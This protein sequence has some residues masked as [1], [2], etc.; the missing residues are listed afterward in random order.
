MPRFPAIARPASAAAVLAAWCA[1]LFCFAAA[2]E[3]HV[4]VNSPAAVQGGYAV[5]TFN[6]PTESDTASTLG[7]RLQLPASTPLAEVSVE[8][9]TGWKF[10]VITGK[11]ATPIET[12]DGPVSEA[13]SEIDWTATGAG[14]APGEF[15]QF[16]VSVGPLP[17][18]PTITFKA[19]QHYSDDKDVAWVEVAGPGSAEPDHPAPTLTLPAAVASS[20]GAASA[21]SA[22]ASVAASGAASG[23][24]SPPSVTVSAAPMDMSATATTA[25]G[26]SRTAVTIA[27][28]TAVLGVLLGAAGL[29]F[30]YTG[31]WPAR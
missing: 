3:A 28:A 14:I 11:L 19:I 30:G 1:G 4:T 13:V 17:M 20:S 26:A 22:A 10:H 27:T 8:A 9:M 18:T 31:R 5:L 12:D 23:A 21:G 2:A 16:N 29:Y 7:L 25:P 24:A 15:G 6:V